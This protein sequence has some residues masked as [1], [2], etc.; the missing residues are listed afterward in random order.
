MSTQKSTQKSK[1]TPPSTYPF[2]LPLVTWIPQ[3]KLAFSQ[4]PPHRLAVGL[5]ALGQTES[6]SVQHH[7]PL[8][9]TF[10]QVFF[11]RVRPAA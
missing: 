7:L 11:A 8:A 1:F 6:Y 5:P 10:C 3:S 4:T 9:T 2:I